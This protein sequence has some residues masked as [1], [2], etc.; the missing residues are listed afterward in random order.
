MAPN[1][2]EKVDSVFHKGSNV[3]RVGIRFLKMV[4]F[5]LGK[6]TRKELVSSAAYATC[7]AF[8]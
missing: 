7:L 4:I 3:I 5:G 2:Q 6:G 1:N 8:N